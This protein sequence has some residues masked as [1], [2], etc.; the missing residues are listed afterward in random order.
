[1]NIGSL[2]FSFLSFSLSLSCIDNETPDDDETVVDKAGVGI[3][4]FDDIGVGDGFANN[5]PPR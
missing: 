5:P 1:M 4:F 3:F 2:S